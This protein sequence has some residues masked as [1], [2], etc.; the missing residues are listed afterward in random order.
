MAQ[1]AKLYDEY[2]SYRTKPVNYREE[3]ANCF[4]VEFEKKIHPVID[5]SLS[6][7][8][9]LSSGRVFKYLR[10]FNQSDVIPWDSRTYLSDLRKVNFLPKRKL[11]TNETYYTFINSN[12]EGY[13]HWITEC[14]VKLF[15][16]RDEL[17]DLNLILPYKM[18]A[19]HHHT[20]EAF[21]IKRST[22]LERDVVFTTPHLRFITNTAGS[23]NYNENVIKELRSFLLAHF[24]TASPTV[25]KRKIYI[26]R[27]KAPRRRIV[28]EDEVE[29]FVTSRGYEKVFM[30]DLDFKA[31][32]NLM[33]QADRLISLHGAGLTNMLFM[34]KDSRVLEMRHEED[35][36]RN[37]YF[38]M[39]SE[40]DIPY[41]YIFC[42][43]EIPGQDPTVA[44][45]IVDM[46]KL[47]KCVDQME[48][49]LSVN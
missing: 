6:N 38:T 41:Y 20:L 23:G 30:E 48:S 32:V 31:Q 42:K 33:N 11:S 7:A 40:L 43:G 8:N 14:L 28:N 4:E 45:H 18:S 5:Y 25:S 15:L 27:Q 9:I 16:V 19:F 36:Y 37:C 21:N 26:S 3:H 10:Y 1:K 12:W 13:F 44:D 22:Q 46:S 39:C 47:K 35:R 34:P 2:V 49:P 17:D 24:V 29:A